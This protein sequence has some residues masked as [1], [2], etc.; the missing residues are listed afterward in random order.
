[1]TKNLHEAK[2]PVPKFESDEAAAEYFDRHSVAAVWNRLV[3]V[4]PAKLS[5][6]L[7]QKACDR[8]ARAKSPNLTS[9][10][11]MGPATERGQKA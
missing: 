2:A 8:R 3:E 10:C 1:M 4:K 7:A 9:A 5:A 11:K 6:A